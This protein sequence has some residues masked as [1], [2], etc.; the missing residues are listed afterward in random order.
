MAYEAAMTPATTFSAAPLR[1]K[2]RQTGTNLD[3]VAQ[4][5]NFISNNIVLLSVLSK[6]TQY[7]E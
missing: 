2:R 3:R 7:T 6:N 5:D 1:Q 4:N